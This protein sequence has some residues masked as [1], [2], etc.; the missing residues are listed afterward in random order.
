MDGGASLPEGNDPGLQFEKAEF[1]TAPSTSVCQRCS[2]PLGRSYFQAGGQVVCE[3]CKGVLEA[4]AAQSSGFGGGRFLRAL[5][6]GIPA[7]ALGA[8]IYYGVSALT[9]YEF[10]LVAILIGLMVGAAVRAG[11]RRRGGWLYQALA[12]FLTYNAIVATYV[13]ALLTAVYENPQETASSSET[14]PA[15]PISVAEA[16]AAVDAA[17]AADSAPVPTAAIEASPEGTS[18]QA[19]AAADEA[20]G[21]LG[22]VFGSMAL[23]AL[24]YAAPFLAG[25][26][27]FI[28]WI[29]I[30]IGLYEAWKLNRRQTLE[31]SGPYELASSAPVPSGGG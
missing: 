10:G 12:M 16:V 5:V 4:E 13:P 31:I 15:E 26:E 14:I 8:G 11:A 25:F 7:A 27:N 29:I 22:C 9:G 28:G 2:L 3:S 6:F 21:L 24:L 18:S 1:A 30:A 17:P 23:L 20:F 19:T